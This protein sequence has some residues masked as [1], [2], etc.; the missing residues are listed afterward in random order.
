MMLGFTEVGN[1]LSLCWPMCQ[2]LVTCGYLNPELKLNKT[3]QFSASVSLV[4]SEGLKRL[5]WLVAK[6][7]DST[8]LE[9]PHDCLRNIYELI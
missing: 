4:A 9:Y 2:P 6:V 1:W 5:L 7:L 8:D 3:W